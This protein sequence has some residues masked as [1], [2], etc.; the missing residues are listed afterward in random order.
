[1]I[2]MFLIPMYKS[3]KSFINNNSIVLFHECFGGGYNV[4]VDMT[5][6]A[7]QNVIPDTKGQ[8]ITVT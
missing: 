3:L 6:A 2:Y 7:V 1:M 4:N 5:K 8:Q